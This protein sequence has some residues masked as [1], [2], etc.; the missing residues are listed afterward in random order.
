MAARR[1]RQARRITAKVLL[2]A[3]ERR[4][5]FGGRALEIHREPERPDKQTGDDCG[6]V[7]LIAADARLRVAVLFFVL[8]PAHR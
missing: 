4:Y 1:R 5:F 2:P 7:L 6:P 8:C 3:V